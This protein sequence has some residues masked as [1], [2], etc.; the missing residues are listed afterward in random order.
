MDPVSLKQKYG[1]QLVFHG[2]IDT[3]QVLTTACEEEVASHVQRTIEILGRGGGYVMAPT[4]ILRPD[5]P[6]ENILA[7]YSAARQ[8]GPPPA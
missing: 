4:Q 5:V 1:E 7:M 6:L 2:G 3:Q 8:S